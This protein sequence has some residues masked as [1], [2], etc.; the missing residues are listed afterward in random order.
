MIC[1]SNSPGGTFIV[2]G[3]SDYYV[4]VYMM[5]NG[6]PQRILETEAHSVSFRFCILNPLHCIKILINEMCLFQKSLY[7]LFF[8][9]THAIFVFIS[10]IVFVACNGLIGV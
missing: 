8:M 5:K 6:L 2:T 3:G 7:L 4:R 10:R 1:S 9:L